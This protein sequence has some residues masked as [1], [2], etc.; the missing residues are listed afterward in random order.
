[1][2]IVAVESDSPA[3]KHG[4][5]VGDLVLAIDGRTIADPADLMGAL[6]GRGGVEVEVTVWRGG[7]REAVKVL[8]VTR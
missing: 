2:V 3:A 4:L 7:A 5:R 8:T 1:M 6:E